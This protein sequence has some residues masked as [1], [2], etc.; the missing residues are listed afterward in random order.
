VDFLN[1]PFSSAALM[2]MRWTGKGCLYQLIL[3]LPP[4]C[5][6]SSPESITVVVHGGPVGKGERWQSVEACMGSLGVV[7]DPPQIERVPGCW[8]ALEQVLVEALVAQAADQALD[9]AVLHRLQ[10]ARSLFYDAGPPPRGRRAHI[11][12]AMAASDFQTRCPSFVLRMS[13]H[14]Q[15]IWPPHQH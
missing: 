1:F 10:G 7:V 2:A 12:F 14:L 6:R 3:T 5:P 15:N 11:L 8:Q 4:C 9:Q 13:S